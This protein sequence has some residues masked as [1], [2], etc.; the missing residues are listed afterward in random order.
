MRIPIFFDGL[1]SRH[2]KSGVPIMLVRDIPWCPALPEPLV[3]PHGR[4]ERA[5]AAARWMRPPEAHGA[6]AQS[7]PL[8][9]R[10][11]APSHWRV[12][13]VMRAALVVNTADV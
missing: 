9:E 5:T 8:P 11:E 7:A 10:V 3:P 6:T 4:H 13:V 2:G 12:V 1:P